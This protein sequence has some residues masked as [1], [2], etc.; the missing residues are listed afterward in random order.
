[1]HHCENFCSAI[2]SALAKQEAVLSQL[3]EDLNMKTD[4]L[5]VSNTYFSFK[6]LYDIDYFTQ[7]FK[8][9]TGVLLLSIGWD[10]MLSP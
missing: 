5:Q 9:D 7:T 2:A 6:S 4:N 10:V 8:W 3:H 1:M